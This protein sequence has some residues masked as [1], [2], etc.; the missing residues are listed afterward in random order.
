MIQANRL[1]HVTEYYFSAKLQE[2]RALEEQGKSII[3]L[4]I[5]SPDLPPPPE[6]I[7]GLNLALLN[8]AA[9]QYQPYKGTAEFRNAVKL[10][11]KI[12]MRLS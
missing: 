7:S 6:V 10:F 4:G 1:N 5:G 11:I 3:N 9:H 12:I 2:V 8:P